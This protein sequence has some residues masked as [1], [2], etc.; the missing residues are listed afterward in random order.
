MRLRHGL[1]GTSLLICCVSGSAFGQGSAPA[2]SA[3][4][5]TLPLAPLPQAPKRTLP[6]PTDAE[7]RILDELLARLRDPD[8]QNRL[9][10]LADV[11]NVDEGLLPAIQARLDREANKADRAKMKT[12]LLD[13]RADARAA[14]EKRMREQHEKGEV[15]TPDYLEMVLRH[16][17]TSNEVWPSLVNVLALSRMCV[18]MKTTK[19]VRVLLTVYVRFE[20]L[21]IDTQ[22]QIAKLGDAALAGLIEATRHQAPK[23]ASWANR[24]LD[25]LGKAIPGEAVQ[26]QDPAMLADVLLAYGLTKEPDAARVVLS[27]TNSER[28]QIRQAARASIASYGEVANWQIRDFYEDMLG[29]RPPREWPWDRT[30]R[31]LFSGLDEMRLEEVYTRYQAGSAALEKKDYRKA[32]EEFDGV[33]RLDPEFEPREAMVQ[34]YIEFAE[35]GGLEPNDDVDRALHSAIRLASDDAVRKRAESLLLTRQ[36]SH[37]A[38][39]KFADR[40]LV[41]RALELDPNNTRAR[42]LERELEREPVVERASFARVLWPSLLVAAGI[43]GAV[44]VLV[45]RRRADAVAR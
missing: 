8:P 39:Q 7:L 18:S 45:R 38:K 14:I 40:S 41:A 3:S 31:E 29:K 12:L 24:Q 26:V 44:T 2:P 5:F 32:V 13:I 19:A 22:L 33:L 17:E 1:V 35:A 23:V 21:R 42:E 6:T 36:A 25:A 16:P 28:T 9:V 30:A 27:F 34:G 43:A 20:F 4:S 11:Q 10:A 15:E 37:Y